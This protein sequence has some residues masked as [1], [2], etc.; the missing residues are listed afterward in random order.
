[1][2]GIHVLHVNCQAAQAPGPYPGTQIDGLVRDPV[3]ACKSPVGDMAVADQKGLGIESGQ[4]VAF[5][6]RGRQ[7]AAPRDGIDR[8]SVAVTRHQNAV[9]FSGN[10]G[11]GGA[12]TPPPRGPV[13][14]ARTFLR[15]EQKGFIG[16]DDAI[17]GLRPVELDPMQEAVASA[18][19]RVAVH[20]N[21][22]CRL[23]YRQ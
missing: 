10:A 1:M 4:Q 3:L 20:A 6:L 7:C 16:F 13:E 22:V 17:Q 8:A 14:R 12:A 18:E 2:I 21:Q 23:A 11:P 15:F 5:E 9:E 19:S